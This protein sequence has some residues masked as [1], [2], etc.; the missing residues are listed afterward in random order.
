[1][2]V[3]A[4]SILYQQICSTSKLGLRTIY[5]LATYFQYYHSVALGKGVRLFATSKS[6]SSFTTAA[7]HRHDK[8]ALLSMLLQQRRQP[9]PLRQLGMWTCQ[10]QK[11]QARRCKRPSLECSSCSSVATITSHTVFQYRPLSIVEI[12]RKLHRDQM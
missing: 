6:G 7:K 2:L 5:R 9:G 11:L 8:V 10:M 4:S 12:T 1:M 3:S